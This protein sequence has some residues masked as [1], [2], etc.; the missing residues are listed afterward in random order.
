MKCMHTKQSKPMCRTGEEKHSIYYYQY[1]FSCSTM[2]HAVEYLKNDTTLS[3]NKAY[4][5]V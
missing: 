5:R 4:R 3:E 2:L 1:G